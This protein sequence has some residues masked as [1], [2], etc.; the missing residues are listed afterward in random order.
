MKRQYIKELARDLR[1]KMTPCEK[2]MWHQLRNKRFKGLKFVRQFPIERYIVDFYC[3]DKKLIIEVDGEIHN[4]VERKAYDSAREEFFAASELRVV[5]FN[6]HD[7][8]NDL[9]RILRELDDIT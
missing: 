4:D 5:R 3:H 1:K 8:E 2:I 6:N 7:I 9:G